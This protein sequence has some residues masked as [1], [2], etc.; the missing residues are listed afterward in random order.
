MCVCRHEQACEIWLCCHGQVKCV[1]LRCCV[2]VAV[3]AI[4]EHEAIAGLTASK[5]AGLRGRASSNARDL[6]E[7]RE[8]M[9]SLDALMRTVSQ[10]PAPTASLT[11]LSVDSSDML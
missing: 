4:L 5:P 1:R 6:E 3:P 9:H 10:P 11:R 2:C 8:S 7:E